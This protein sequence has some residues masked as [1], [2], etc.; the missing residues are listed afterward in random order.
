MCKLSS[1]AIGFSIQSCLV[2]LFFGHTEYYLTLCKL[3]SNAFV[4][5]IKD[6]FLCPVIHIFS[7]FIP[8]TA[9]K[10]YRKLETNIPSKG[11]AWPQ[12][13]F[14]PSCVCERFLY[15]HNRSAYSA[16]GNM[17]TDHENIYIYI[18]YR[19]INFELGLR[20]RNSQKRNT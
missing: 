11:I 8:C 18:A 3:S 17:W 9:K 4:R 13:Q 14:P 6:V 12:S 19:H 1:N 10:Q 20:P 15:S 2:W 5:H 16:A 7:C